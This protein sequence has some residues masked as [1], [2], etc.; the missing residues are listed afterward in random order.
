MM[1][2]P[3]GPGQLGWHTAVRLPRGYYVRVASNEYSVHP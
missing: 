3:I 1:A 2:L